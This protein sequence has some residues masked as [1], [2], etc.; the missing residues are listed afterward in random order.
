M[1]MGVWMLVVPIPWH[2]SSSFPQEVIRPLARADHREF[3]GLGR[4]PFCHKRKASRP[5]SPKPGQRF[6]ESTSQAPASV[7]GSWPSDPPQPPAH[8]R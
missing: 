1:P 4:D 6:L 8:L 5:V 3:S 2:S 7:H